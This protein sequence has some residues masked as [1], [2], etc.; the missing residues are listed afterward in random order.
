LPLRTQ[1]VQFARSVLSGDF[2]DS[3]FY[4]R[5]ALSLVLSRLPATLELTGVAIGLAVLVGL[6]SGVVAASRRGTAWDSLTMTGAVLGRSGPV[7]WLA[8][9]LIFLFA[10]QW[11]I[12]PASGRAGPWSLVL[13]GFTL[14]IV[15]AAEIARL[16]RS[17]M[18]EVLSQD[19]VRTGYA[20]GLTTGRVIVLHALRNALVP[21]VTV[22][23]LQLGTLLGGAV[24]TE[25]IFAWPGVGR[26]T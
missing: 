19:Y 23:G 25:T 12:L 17:S 18:V 8:L 21:I 26:L 16:T 15:S 5:S 11:R 13:P 24:I 20:K 22:V 3:F 10:V 14:G 4:S 6:T 7:F 1:F 2:G 9:L